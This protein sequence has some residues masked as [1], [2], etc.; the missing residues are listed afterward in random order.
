MTRL[1]FNSQ[2]KEGGR[3]GEG[4]REGGEK[5]ERWREERWGGGTKKRRE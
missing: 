4:E 1:V 5:G 3:E 2:P